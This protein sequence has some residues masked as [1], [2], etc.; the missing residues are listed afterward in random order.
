M[1]VCVGES[2]FAFLSVSFSHHDAVHRFGELWRTWRH[3]QSIVG[4]VLVEA[5]LAR[6]EVHLLARAAL[7][8]RF[9]LLLAAPALDKPDVAGA[10]A[11]RCRTEEAWVQADV[12]E[13][14]HLLAER[15]AALQKPP[16]S[17]QRSLCLSR[18]CLGK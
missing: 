5:L 4:V 13:R 9:V 16:L 10:E 3:H 18:A 14:L 12:V 2:R 17:S 6:N 7:L 15:E 11:L 1:C 8:H